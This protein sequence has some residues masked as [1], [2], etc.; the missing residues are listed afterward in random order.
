MCLDLQRYPLIGG[1]AQNLWDLCQFERLGLAYSSPAQR[2]HWPMDRAPGTFGCATAMVTW[3]KSACWVSPRNH[4][5]WHLVT[6]SA[7][8]G[9]YVSREFQRAPK[10]EILWDSLFAKAG[11]CEL[12]LSLFGFLR[13][14]LL[15]ASGCKLVVGLL[16]TCFVCILCLNPINWWNIVFQLLDCICG[17]YLLYGVRLFHKFC[18]FLIIVFKC[19]FL[20]FIFYYE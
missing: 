8:Q 3:V 19:L 9:S 15:E 13:F 16:G 18:C 2:P 14:L 17:V 10:G 4:H 12:G 11:R 5:K 1:P 7:T 20:I 6:E